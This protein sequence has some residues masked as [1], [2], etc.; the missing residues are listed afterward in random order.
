MYEAIPSDSR[1]LVENKLQ[2]LLKLLT[3]ADLVEYELDTDR[4]S[5]SYAE[6]ENSPQHDHPGSLWLYGAPGVGSLVQAG[7]RIRNFCE[8]LVP[9][10]L[11]PLSCSRCLI[12]WHVQVD[13]SQ[14]KRAIL[15][16]LG[17]RGTGS[18]SEAPGQ[19]RCAR[20]WR[21]KRV[22]PAAPELEAACLPGVDDM[23]AR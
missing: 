21:R 22:I 9:T 8:L 6:D 20:A 16:G 2:Y 5:A 7:I 23:I 19:T 15:I 18:N 11:A 4:S 12:L 13:C 17:R 14:L 3:P 10:R 1:C